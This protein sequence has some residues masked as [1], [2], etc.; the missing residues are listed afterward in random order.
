MENAIQLH[1]DVAGGDFVEAGTASGHVKKVLSQIG[2]DPAAIRR[3]A[4]AMYEGEIN[5]VIH[6]N[7]GTA[8][9][10]VTKDY[11]QIVLRDSGPGI[12]DISLA[13]Q[14]GYSTAS[15]AARDMGFGAG[16]GLPNMKSYTDE[17]EL[18]SEVGVGT[19]VRMKINL[20]QA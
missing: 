4:I 10:E 14:A 13:M 9:V 20:E 19:T 5:M 18:E 1:Y 17:M 7:G 3:A 8:D 15:Q 11:I 6:A 2:I 12:K 16:M